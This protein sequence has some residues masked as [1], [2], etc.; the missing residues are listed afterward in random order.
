MSRSIS[1]P[2]FGEDYSFRV[3]R[4]FSRLSFCLCEPGL[5]RDNYLGKVTITY[6]E[7]INSPM[8]HEQWR[9]LQQMDNDTEVQVSLM[10]FVL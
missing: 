5:H 8:K 6:Q 3:P 2:F 10:I 9:P 7:L 1:S 4:D